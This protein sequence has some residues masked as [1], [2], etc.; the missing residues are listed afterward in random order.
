M[1]EQRLEILQ[2][3]ANGEMTSEQADEQLL[4]LSNISVSPD[5][6]SEEDCIKAVIRWRE[7]MRPLTQIVSEKDGVLIR[8]RD[9]GRM[10]IACE[11]HSR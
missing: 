2:K 1:K 9:A 5:I 4:G 3:L 7:Y 8:Y 10:L 11:K 6:D